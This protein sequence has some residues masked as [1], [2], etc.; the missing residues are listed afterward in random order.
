GG[1]PRRAQVLGVLAAAGAVRVHVCARPR[2]GIVST[3]DEV[4]PPD[5]TPQPGQVRDATA[6]AL[7]ALVADA[8]GRPEPYGIAPDDPDA[9]RGILEQA[10]AEC[11]LAVVSAGSSVGARDATAE[12]IAGLGPPGVFCH[13]LA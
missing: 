11:D 1:R 2:V 4:V 6:H 3:G 13:G 12:V 8:G 9:M 5:E 7:A 10:V